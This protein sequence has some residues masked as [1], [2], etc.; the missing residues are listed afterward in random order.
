MRRPATLAALVIAGA[1]ALSP[2]VSAD[3]TADPGTVQ[4]MRP[5]SSQA[6][7]ASLDDKFLA[8]L[9]GSGIRVSDVRA[10]IEGAKDICAFLAAGHDATEVIAQG[11]A[12][13]PSMT[14]SDEIAAF[15]AAVGAYCPS[16]LRLSG[17]LA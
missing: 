6:S 17:T 8:G 1:I 15:N 7:T 12:N 16:R 3:P 13:N 14:R 5:P 4:T 2:P 11:M 9:A 10:A